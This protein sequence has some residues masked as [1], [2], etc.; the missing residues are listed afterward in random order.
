MNTTG[1]S[2]IIEVEKLSKAFGLLP[3]LKGLDFTVDR[4]DYVLL[5]GA[6]GSGKST[7]LRLLS[8]L[9]K[10]TAGTIRIGGWELP[11]EVMA[12][13]AQIGLIAHHP[14][15][16]EN[17][18][19]GENLDFYGKLYGI[20]AD[21][22]EQ[23]GGELLRRVG[24]SRRADSLVR[25]FS[26]GMKQRLSIARALLHQPDLLLLD[27]PYSGLDQAACNLLDDLLAAARQAG[28]TIMLS[29]HQLERTPKAAER[30]LVL[31]GGEIAFDGPADRD[32]LSEIYSSA[33]GAQTA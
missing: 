11:R 25:T 20:E 8:G 1:S 27:E 19:A 24:L 3:A 17:L 12:V 10:P 13:R 16:Y 21:I 14:L 28:R 33:T 31:S 30:A 5:F 15:L 4:G 26:R 2:A 32:S 9:C 23:R 29:T 18:T 22:R 7:L 6:N